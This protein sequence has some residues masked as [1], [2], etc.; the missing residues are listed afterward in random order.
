MSILKD[1]LD[2]VKDFDS[3]TL[4]NLITRR[5]ATSLSKAASEGTLQFP[6]LI[7]RSLDIS[8]LNMMCAALERE[9]ASFA[10]IAMTMDQVANQR[11]GVRGYL[12][13][14]HQNTGTR[15]NR[16]D[17]VNDLVTI[18]NNFNESVEFIYTTFENELNAVIES[19]VAKGCTM[20]VRVDNQEQLYNV[21]EHLNL[22]KLN[23]KFRPKNAMIMRAVFEA[24]NGGNNNGQ[25]PQVTHDYN[26]N[27]GMIQHIGYASGNSNITHTN[28]N[29]NERRNITTTAAAVR[30]RRIFNTQDILK[31]NDVKKSNEL[32]P[33]TL[34]IRVLLVNDEDHP[35]DSV[36]FIV[37]IKAI[38]HP[39]NSQEMIENIYHGCKQNGPF[40]NFIRWTTGEISFM[41]DLILRVND[42]KLDVYNQSAGASKWWIALKRRKN[43][44]R[45]RNQVFL[46]G[47][48]LP[49]TSVVMN[50]DEVEYIKT[51]YG[52]DLMQERIAYKIM[53]EYF[54]LAFVVVDMSGEIA[55]FLFDG[56]MSYQSTTFEGLRKETSNT[57][58]INEVIKMAN[59]LKI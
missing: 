11:E 1:F 54:L 42:T 25:P 28:H 39:I 49:N 33:T 46:P 22:D 16:F 24:G 44:S 31:D 14:F 9:F 29:I 18:G 27:T 41:K 6:V 37:G 30:D 38:M 35:I 17:L 40:F 10:Q 2:L 23:D 26:G 3:T 57:N 12:R 50:M 36:D 48:L 32:V 47:G 59:R 53:Q 55:H 34:H 8:T 52:Y 56:D 20:K 4:D 19:R 21:L 58:T 45:L 7:T 51:R 5:R 43:L 13:R 15:Y